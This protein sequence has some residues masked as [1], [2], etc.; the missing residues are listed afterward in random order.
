[1]NLKS[2]STNIPW[3]S[4]FNAGTG[5]SFFF[6]AKVGI[7][8]LV[9][10]LLNSN[11]VLAQNRDSLFSNFHLSLPL[12][13]T[14]CAQMEVDS[15]GNVY[16]LHTGENKLFKY[17][18]GSGFDSLISLGGKSVRQEGLIQPIKFSASNR[19]N[20][21]V[22]DEASRRILVLSPNFRV[23]E[24]IDFTKLNYGFELQKNS[25]DIYPLS[26]D[27]NPAGELFVLNQW[28]NKVYKL[29]PGE[30]TLAF[31]GTDFGEG[32]LWNPTDIRVS[33][34]NL[35]WVK[36][37][38]VLKVYDAFG[39]FRYTVHPKAPF[40]WQQFRLQGNFLLCFDQ[41]TLF[42]RHLSTQE[43]SLH[44]FPDHDSVVDIQLSREYVYLLF[45][46]T[47]ALYKN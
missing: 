31:G 35:I 38:Q 28:D 11:S 1:M 24:A 42:M 36:D 43:S 19:Q 5:Y 21:Y 8:C 23:N 47:L 18:S 7:L 13:T 44:T 30:I 39:H 46:N 17:L 3:K 4:W 25:Q 27:V 32:S 40:K 33:S 22:L 2:R 37:E 9:V 34:D 45:R 29:L 6:S 16:L 14:D 12:P 15:E 20:T 41:H 26:F 10:V